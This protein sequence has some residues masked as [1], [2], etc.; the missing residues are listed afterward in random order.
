VDD[1]RLAFRQAKVRPPVDL[2]STGG[3]EPSRCGEACCRADC[4][5]WPC[6]DGVDDL[7]APRE[8]GA[9][10]SH[11]EIGV[12][13]LRNR[14]GQVID[15]VQAG[16]RVTLTVRG[17]PVADIVPHGRRARWLSG[18]QLRGQLRDRAADPGLTRDLDELAGQTLDEL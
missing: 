13:D 1:V 14:T 11:M 18:E 8:A 5:R 9:T 10:L 3:L 16:E 17:E 15:A 12:R 7:G 6:V 4:R 2:D